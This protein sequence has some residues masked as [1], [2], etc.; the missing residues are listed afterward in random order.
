MIFIEFHTSFIVWIGSGDTCRQWRKS[1]GGQGAS[2]DP[3]IHCLHP[4]VLH[5]FL[6][7]VIFRYVGCFGRFPPVC[8]C[9]WA[10]IPNEAPPWPSDQTDIGSRVEKPPWCATFLLPWIN[11]VVG[12]LGHRAMPKGV[13]QPTK[14]AQGPLPRHL[15]PLHFF[16][17]FLWKFPAYK[18]FCKYKWN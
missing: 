16:C 4:I 17:T 2:A 6:M 7:A 13:G 18:Y 12:Q 3:W 10:T 5:G 1:V 8:G 9:K 14:W 11:D 15:P